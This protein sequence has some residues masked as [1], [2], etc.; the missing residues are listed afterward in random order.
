MKKWS[1]FINH[2]KYIV[3]CREFSRFRLF[4]TQIGYFD[5]FLNNLD[6]SYL[7]QSP[8]LSDYFSIMEYVDIQND[9]IESELWKTIKNLHRFRLFY[10]YGYIRTFTSKYF[11]QTSESKSEFYDDFS[12]CYKQY[13]KSK[14]WICNHCIIHGNEFDKIDAVMNYLKNDIGYEN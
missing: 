8:C 10:T 14:S 6:E 3:P 9:L 2:F 4:L 11:F 12:Y 7:F 5:E 1:N 13:I